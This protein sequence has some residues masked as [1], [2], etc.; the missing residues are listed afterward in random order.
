MTPPAFVNA[1]SSAFFSVSAHPSNSSVCKRPVQ[2]SQVSMM[3]DDK[4]KNPLSGLGGTYCAMTNRSVDCMHAN[5]IF[6]DKGIGNIMDA[7]KK[8]QE[9]TSVAK[10]LQEQL[11]NTEIEATVREGQVKVIMTAQQLPIKIEVTDEL[12]ALGSAEVRIASLLSV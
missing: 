3:A 12:V 2:A 1:A 9:F 4:G 11:K 7:M 6:D 10:D 8:A 5:L